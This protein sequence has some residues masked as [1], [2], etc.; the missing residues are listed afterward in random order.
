MSLATKTVIVAAMSADAPLV[1]LLAKDPDD[2]TAPAIF[3]GHK[4][5]TPPVY[6]SVTYRIA[7]GAPDRRFRP[8][9][10]VGGGPSTV[11][12]EYLEIEAWTQKPDCAD[13]EA[14]AARLVAIFD[15]RPLSLTT[16]R[17]FRAECVMTQSDLYDKTLNASF[18]L[19]RYRLRIAR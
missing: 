15:G 8:A 2:S 13:L 11:Q 17:V 1:A 14:I 5:Q 18:L 12:D 10:N 3:N 6:N 7:D 4:S 9:I 19:A 16:G